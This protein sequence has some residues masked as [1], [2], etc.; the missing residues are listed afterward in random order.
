MGFFQFSSQILSWAPSLVFLAFSEAFG[1]L[2]LAIVVCPA[3]WLVGL[4]VLLASVDVDKGVGQVAHTLH[5]RTHQDHDGL[6]L[7]DTAKEGLEADTA[8]DGPP[9]EAIEKVQPSSLA[10]V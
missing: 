9:G 2:R 3:F 10:S 1:D 6:E 4:V 8:K 7:T 5:L